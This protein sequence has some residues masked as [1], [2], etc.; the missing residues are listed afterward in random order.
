M[1]GNNTN[2]FTFLK[3]HSSRS[4]EDTWRVEAGEQ[5]ERFYSPL[6]GKMM[7]A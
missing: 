1:Q 4:A 3:D 6:C 7:M 5:S 2:W